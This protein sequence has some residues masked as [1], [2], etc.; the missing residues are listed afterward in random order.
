VARH[1]LLHEVGTDGFRFLL[2]RSGGL[3]RGARK[4]VAF[5][6]WN[7]DLHAGVSLLQL[8]SANDVAT[9][10]DGRVLL[11]HGSAALLAPAEARVLGLPSPCPYALSLVA[12]GA[13]S[14][15]NFS[16]RVAWLDRNGA[17]VPGL[18][19][20]GASIATAV[21]Q[22]I[23]AEP[24]FTLLEEVEGMNGLDNA[25][26]RV[27][28]DERMVKLARVKQALEAATGDASADRYLSRVTISHAT[29]IGIDTTGSRDAPFFKPL[30]YGDVPPSPGAI[31]NEDIEIERQPLL[32]TDQA[33][34]FQDTMFPNQ[35]AW[36]HYR[37]GEGAYVVL[38]AAVVSALRV[39]QKINAADAQIRQRFRRDPNS[40][41][42]PEIE[43]A[44]G[45]GDVLCGG[46]VLA[47]DE[48][49]DYGNRVLGVAEWQGRA[50]SFKIP[51]H[52]QWFPGDDA[53]DVYPID[54]PG[55]EEPLVVRKSGLEQLI[56]SV[57]RAMS[58]DAATFTHN[59][60]SYPLNNPK[61]LLGTLVGLTGS[62]SP[63][64]ARGRTKPDE[65]RK[66][67]V[68][69]VAENEED[70]EYLARLRDPDGT[71]AADDSS[72]I[73]GMQSVPDPHQRDGIG[74]LKACFLSGMP[75]TLLADDMGLGKTFQVLAFLH[76]LRQRGGTDGRPVLLVAPA[77]LLEEWLEQVEIHLPP[78]ALGRPALA[79]DRHLRDYKLEK[80]NE[81]TLG[82]STLDVERLRKA[83]WVITT[84]ETLRDHQF[85]FGKV[86]YRIAIFDEAQKIKSGTSMLNHAAKAQQPDFVILMTGT[87]IENSV[88]DI[89][90]LLD[91]AWP[92]F[93]GVSGK[94]FVH[95]YGDGSDEGLMTDLKSRLIES[96]NW[97]NGE[98]SRA[99]PPVM[100]RRFKV[101]V[102]PGLPQKTESPLREEM[103]PAQAR[104]Y[105][106]IISEMQSGNLKPL[107]ALQAL[108]KVCLHP[109]LRLP[110][111]AAD[112]QAFI[113][114]SAR[115]RALFRVL[116][117][118]HE[119]EQG[120]LVFIDLRH[121][122]MLLQT[123][124]R[125]EF[126][127]PKLPDIINGN[128][129]IE[130]VST[131]K[132]EFQNGKGF[133]VLLLGPRAAGFG[134]TLTRATQVVHLNRWWNPAVED[135]CSDRTHRKGQTRDVTV[136]LPIAVHPRLGDESFDL[137]LH[138]LLQ[139]KRSLSRRVVVPSSMSERELAEFF[140]RLVAGS[141]STHDVLVDLDRKDW[142]SFEMWV[143]NCFQAAGWQVNDTPRTGD[144]GAD[145]IARHPAGGRPIIVQAKHRMLGIGSVDESA[146]IEVAGAPKRYQSSRP[147]LADPILLAVSNGTFELQAHTV[148]IQ[149]GVRIV[150][151]AEI[152]GLDGVARELFGGARKH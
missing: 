146:V 109:D 92:G 148:A 126:R 117:Q 139:H 12:K 33:M 24:L 142:R 46:N 51:V 78:M 135:Q 16:I 150:G 129:A 55:A 73:P 31:D 14:D 8:L 20:T 67:I 106:A 123:M 83:D 93:L 2:E 104:A 13:F 143:A 52:Q 80:G 114:A 122:Q 107:V 120:V 21:D 119:K 90:T 7:E 38:D 17:E 88:M 101:D 69:R 99:T 37:L 19:R 113:A 86:R 131:I 81:S 1:E 102:L 89:W 74:W 98:T 87:P 47:P 137:I 35:G 116:H 26:S 68:L 45:G 79:Y 121:P 77:K 61:E 152:T 5:D 72:D 29:G 60:R 22:F 62:V 147:W 84:Y 6:A 115:F 105:D 40:F 70:L 10:V 65:P 145:V 144:G 91:V 59:G 130:A 11:S 58:A 94:E 36:S 97:G 134:L 9:I 25:T 63:D 112:R 151:R 110:R 141:A 132:K 57:E 108:R 75:G 133:G 149:K 54:V 103:P 118:A 28:L 43:A 136:H 18:I 127:L 56:D 4:E 111:D 138:E 95:R 124:I 71:L 34:T 39:V 100:Q 27:G 64:T 41:L 140:S 66:R 82:R 42:L 125:D 15:P 96:Q 50:F 128:T 76:W 30:L 3:F 48:F 85:S 53:E 49:M 32:P 23:V 44:G